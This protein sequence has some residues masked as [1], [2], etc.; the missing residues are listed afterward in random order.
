MRV[1]GCQTRPRNESEYGREL[2][3]AP[4]TGPEV[5]RWIRVRA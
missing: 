3:G 1:F 4:S 5:Y 2:R